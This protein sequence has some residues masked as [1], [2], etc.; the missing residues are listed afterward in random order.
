LEAQQK[1]KSIEKKR[2]W[3]ETEARDFL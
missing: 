1:V 3:K 2:K